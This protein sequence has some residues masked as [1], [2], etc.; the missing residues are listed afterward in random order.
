M[1]A[2]CH[3]RHHVCS[4][5]GRTFRASFDVGQSGGRQQRVYYPQSRRLSEF[6]FASLSPMTLTLLTRRGRE[7]L[8]EMVRGP[9]PSSLFR[10]GVE[11]VVGRFVPRIVSSGGLVL[12]KSGCLRCLEAS[13]PSRSPRQ[14]TFRCRILMKLNVM[15]YHR[16]TVRTLL[17]PRTRNC[18]SPRL[19]H[20]A[21]GNSAID[22][23]R[24][25]TAFASSVCMR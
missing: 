24:R 13:F 22:G 25:K 15:A 5:H 21:L 2:G 7:F 4:T 12:V 8:R 16:L 19:R 17:R 6:Q 14:S 10:L 1:V 11:G 3:P 23:R 9:F 20:S 18:C